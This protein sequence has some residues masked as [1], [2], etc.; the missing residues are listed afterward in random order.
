[1]RE[2]IIAIDGG[3]VTIPANSSFGALRFEILPAPVPAGQS[4]TL[5]FVLQGNEQ[6]KPSNNYARIGYRINP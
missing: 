5:V 6:I 3:A 1:M 2:C 4:F